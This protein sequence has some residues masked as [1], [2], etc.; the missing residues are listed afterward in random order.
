MEEKTTPSQQR[1]NAATTR[2]VQCRLTLQDLPRESKY[3]SGRDGHARLLV[4]D[5]TITC[6][7][8]LQYEAGK[9]E[10]NDVTNTHQQAAKS[11][12]E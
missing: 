11:C 3:G 8:T 5:V 9:K 12:R 10:Y 2:P 7:H 6:T 4:C 1:H